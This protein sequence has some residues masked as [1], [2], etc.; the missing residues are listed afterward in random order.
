MAE[1][2]TNAPDSAVIEP[3][4][5]S[6]SAATVRPRL[7]TGWAYS[8]L[9]VVS[10]A[11][12]VL[13]IWAPVSPQ[14]LHT[15]SLSVLTLHLLQLTV[16]V[17]VIG[18]WFIALWGSLRFK[19]YALAIYHDPDGRAL[20][21]VS[22]GLLLLVGSLAITSL[23]QALIPR[24]TAVGDG[25]GWSILTHHT[26]VV[27]ALLAF[28]TMFVGS[29]RLARL[30]QLRDFQRWQWLVFAA[31]LVMGVV[32]AIVLVHDP[33]RTQTTNPTQH[34]SYYLTDGWIL[35]TIVLPYLLSWYF[36][37]MAAA[38]LWMYQVYS[39]GVIYRRALSRLSVGLVV[40]IAT[41]VLIQ[42]LSAAASSLTRLGLSDILVLLYVLI[43]VYALGHVLVVIG[44]RRLTT[45]EEVQ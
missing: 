13:T 24:L 45:I 2:S 33:Y 7:H 25:T 43:I 8:G 12:L 18:I 3:A 42:L 10:A 32:Y 38:C 17:P 15:Y 40:I 5:V 11:Y 6:S 16:V 21:L 29:L 14:T 41:S 23:M 34:P 4:K 19:R 30:V 22:N 37:L 1:T 36:G 26:T 9:A 35:G 39:P 27:L 31:L 44:A 20:N 28:A